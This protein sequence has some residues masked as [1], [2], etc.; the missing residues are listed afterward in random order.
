MAR[1]ILLVLA[2]I[3]LI[4]IGLFWTGVLYWPGGNQPVQANPVKVEMKETTVNVVRPEI[5]VQNGAQP[6]P[7]N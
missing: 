7:A 5:S 2:L 6:A 4:V 1:T 3:V